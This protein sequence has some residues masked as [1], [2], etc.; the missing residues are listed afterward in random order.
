MKHTFLLL[1]LVALFA[2]LSTDVQAQYVDVVYCDDHHHHHHHCCQDH[3]IFKNGFFFDALVQGGGY[4]TNNLRFGRFHRYA[5]ARLGLRF[6]N[7]WY[8]GHMDRYRPGLTVTWAKASVVYLLEDSYSSY[9]IYN[10]SLVNLG[11]TNAFR[12]DQHSGLELNINTGFNLVSDVETDDLYPGFLVNAN[13]KYR[14]KKIAVGLDASYIYGSSF[15]RPELFVESIFVGA[16]VG[17]KF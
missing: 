4:E 15:E 10:F 6:G 12:F 3:K 13:I 9:P 2:F 16:T 17:F 7:K 1:Q 5:V 8:F 11:F 14:Y